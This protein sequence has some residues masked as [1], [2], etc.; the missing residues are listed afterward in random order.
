[1]V[2]GHPLDFVRLGDAVTVRVGPDE[3]HI[4]R[5]LAGPE[6]DDIGT[7]LSD[8]SER[9]YTIQPGDPL[10]AVATM[11][12]TAGF[13][14]EGWSAKIWTCSEQRATATEFHLTAR[15]KA[16]SGDDL[17]FEEE[18]SFVIPRNGM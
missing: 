5:I 17:I 4:P 7:V 9:R 10:S 1:M 16:W 15:L 14:R 3:Q 13:D 12:Q 18:Q 6:L 8:M 11:E 2:L